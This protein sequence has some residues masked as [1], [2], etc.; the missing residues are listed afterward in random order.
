MK[1]KILDI[2]QI[3]SNLKKKHGQFV[4]KYSGQIDK[5]LADQK[6]LVDIV[7]AKLYRIMICFKEERVVDDIVMR[8]N[9]PC[10]TM[11][12]T[13]NSSRTY[14]DI[15]TNGKTI[16]LEGFSYGHGFESD[17]NVD[18]PIKRFYNVDSEDFDWVDFSDKLLDFIHY[19][20]YDRKE[21][22][23]QKVKE[24]FFSDDATKRKTLKK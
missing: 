13:K 3:Q 18:I 21:V 15:K 17:I 7:F 24:Y 23:E 20:I 19:T 6:F 1:P 11:T 22:L 4:S 8:D 9:A 14:V 12:L 2:P 10:K 16:V 5:V